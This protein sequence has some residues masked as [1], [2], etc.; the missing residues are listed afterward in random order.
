MNCPNVNFRSATTALMVWVIAVA[1]NLNTCDAVAQ[2]SPFAAA[3]R[4]DNMSLGKAAVV[5]DAVDTDTVF[6]LTPDNERSAVGLVVRSVRRQNPQTPEELAQAL[7]KLIDVEAWADAKVYLDQL[8]KVVMDDRALYRLYTIRG[9]EFFYILHSVEELAPDSQSFAKRV[10]SA[11]R[12][13]ATSDA[14]IRSLVKTLSDPDINVRSAAFEKIKIV[15]P[16]A[17]AAMLEVFGDDARSDLWP[18]VRGAVR[19][20][21]DDATEVLVAGATCGNRQIEVESWFGLANLKTEEAIDLISFLYLS[22]QTADNVK[23]FAETRLRNYFGGS[24]DR[25]SLI[26]GLG[27]KAN[28]SLRG[29][30]NE[31]SSDAKVSVWQYQPAANKFQLSRV[32]LA[33][34]SRI[35]AAHMAQLL[36]EID[37]ANR[38][39][40]ALYLLSAIESAK[41]QAGPDTPVDA[42]ALLK[43]LGNPEAAELNQLLSRS[44][45]RAIIP[46]SIGICELLK[47][48]NDPSVLYSGQGANSALV[49]AVLSGERYLQFAALDAIVSLDPATAYPGSSW[50]VD[51]AAFMANT[52]GQQQVLVGHYGSDDSR[53]F[54]GVVAT[55]GVKVQSVRNGLEF[56]NAAVS[57]PD[58]KLLLLTDNMLRPQFAQVLQQLRADWRTRHL[59]V[60][61]VVSNEKNRLIVQRLAKSDPL[62]RIID[63][64]FDKQIVNSQLALFDGLSSSWGLTDSSRVIHASVASQWLEKLSG[65]RERYGFYNLLKHEETVFRMLYIAGK[66]RQAAAIAARLGTARAQRELANFA[67]QNGQAL[68]DR[69]SAV[70]GFAAAVKEFGLLLTTDEIRLQYQRYNSSAAE[71]KDVQAVFG[72]ILDAIEKKA[73]KLT[74]V[75]E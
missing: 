35:R 70:D 10:L 14:R 24:I 23:A 68:A 6:R 3:R 54:G 31:I 65:D 30:R 72:G 8:S 66:A 18:G 11:A 57:S 71:T 51:L 13:Y 15:G 27:R 34:A 38:Q 62:I 41:K 25:S 53:T 43:E 64:N 73:P 22:P 12:N 58:W 9:A 4:D 55:T 36:V 26:A 5:P 16:Q 2:D 63:L 17:Y 60:G 45:N 7:S 75:V 74:N 29:H 61:V 33:V 32:S 69:Q 46:A 52:H 40:R 59:P 48:L 1:G 39:N 20:L 42:K 47:E 56:Y 50:V 67:S 28:Q 49:K 37:P 44:L 21:G 19:R